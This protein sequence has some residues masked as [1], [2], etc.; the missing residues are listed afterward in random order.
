[1]TRANLNF[2]WQELGSHPRTLYFY[3]NGDQY[4]SGLRD[5][6]GVKAW[7]GKPEAFTPEGFKQW[8]RTAYFRS[9]RESHPDLQ[10]EAFGPEE[11]SHPAIHYDTAGFPTDYSY[12]FEVGLMPY[13][14]RLSQEDQ[15]KGILGRTGWKNGV[16]VYNW[17]E[18]I[19]KGTVEAFLTWLDSQPQ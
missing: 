11:I 12:L 8:V 16:R 4:P 18:R 3:Y 1:M 7:L 2:V 14:I 19:F 15:A 5:H 9:V 6:F 13:T 17:D 10:V